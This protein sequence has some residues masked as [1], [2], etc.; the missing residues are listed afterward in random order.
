MWLRHTNMC[1]CYVPHIGYAKTASAVESERRENALDK[2]L[3]LQLGPVTVS[4]NSVLI[5]LS[6]Q[7]SLHAPVYE[8]GKRNT[9][10]TKLSM[11]VM[12]MKVV[13]IIVMM[14]MVEMAMMMIM[15]KSSTRIFQ[16]CIGISL[17]VS[18][19]WGFES[20]MGSNLLPLPLGPFVFCVWSFL[21]GTNPKSHMQQEFYV[22]DPTTLR[23]SPGKISVGIFLWEFY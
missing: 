2:F 1:S 17:S 21:Y 22:K 16:R 9:T 3:I 15:T 18:R 14:M 4:L 20:G 6:P 8:P 7:S 19:R 12:I 5:R 23:K 13:L 11:V 10:R